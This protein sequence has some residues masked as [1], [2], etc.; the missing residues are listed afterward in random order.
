[1]KA[2]KTKYFGPSNVRGSR[3]IASD[4]DGNRIILSWADNLN[5]D[6]NHRH[7]A[8]M[9]CKKMNWTGRLCM[10]KLKD[11]YIHT[12]IADWTAYDVPK[13]NKDAA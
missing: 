11:S 6:E 12:F 8:M 3:V 9:L 10:G 1:M 4:D 5:G 2:I 7:A 13:W